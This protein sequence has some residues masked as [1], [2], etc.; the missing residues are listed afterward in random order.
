M[1]VEERVETVRDTVRRTEVEVEDDRA[2]VR[3]AADGK[4][5]VPGAVGAAKTA[6]PQTPVEPATRR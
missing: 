4:A 3:G 6:M 5:G 2:T 1:G